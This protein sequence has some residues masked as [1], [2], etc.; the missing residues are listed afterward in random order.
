M[1]Y[2]LIVLGILCL[3]V[4][5]VG[6]VVPMVPGPPIAYAGMVLLHFSGIVE[7]SVALFVWWG[8]LVFAS[9]LLD[10]VIPVMG[11]KYFGGSRY[12]SWG[13]IVGTFAGLFM[14]PFGI[15]VG[16]FLGACIGELIA[17]R[18]FSEALK[19]AVGSFLGFL[20]G[21]LLKLAICIYFIYE[22]I[23]AVC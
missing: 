14:G 2:L 16:P 8:L 5:V 9:V 3:V 7:F 11:T 4:G 1:E 10:Y 21:T 18:T 17:N 19:S 6:C 15:I 23:V 13:C 20:C 22:V 12:G